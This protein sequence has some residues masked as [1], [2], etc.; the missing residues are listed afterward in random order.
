MADGASPVALHAEISNDPLVQGGTARIVVRI[1]VDNPFHVQSAHPNDEYLIPTSVEVSGP[2]AICAGAVRYPVATE[3]APPP[4]STDKPLSVYQNR[5]YVMVPLT[6]DQNAPVGPGKI[7][8]T[9]TTQACNADACNPPETKKIEIPVTV[10]AAGTATK[11]KDPAF[12]AA[13]DKQ[14]FM[15]PT[16]APAPATQVVSEPARRAAA[17]TGTAKEPK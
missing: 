11:T 12:F 4:G 9:V 6:I 7:T 5:V 14:K 3:T 1:V 17:A 8:V 13:A 15:E 16:I 2:A 10:A